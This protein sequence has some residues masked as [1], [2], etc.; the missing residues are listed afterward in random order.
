MPFVHPYTRIRRNKRHG[1]TREMFAE[2]HIHRSQLILPIFVKEGEQI[3]I[4]S[5]PDVNV[6]SMGLCIDTVKRAYNEGISAVALFPRINKSLKDEFGG[7][8]IKPNNLLCKTISAIKKVVPDIGII[9]DIALDPYTIHG[10]DGVLD[11]EG[12]VD[13]DKTVE[14]LTKQALILADSGCDILAPSDMMDGR[15]RSIRSALEENKFLN[16]QIFSYAAKY[17]SKLYG[18]FRE[19]VDS[20][21]SLG[22]T[23]KKH[24]QLNPANIN[25]AMRKVKLDIAEGADAIIVKPSL[26][27]LDVVREIKN[28]Y[29]TPVITYQVSGEYTALKIAAIQGIYSYEDVQI[30]FL[31]SCKRAGA[32]C[33]ITY[34]A[35]EIAKLLPK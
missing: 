4:P 10:H 5:M 14:I 11:I 29:P 21:I 24:Y 30:E 9:A 27:Y 20:S 3:A 26:F 28:S 33:V 2:N 16:T 15:I 6:L 7:Y 23:D 31:L 34:G 8:A 19:A 17:A 13:N 12:L 22:S 1:W 25:E 35:L 32:S 18:P